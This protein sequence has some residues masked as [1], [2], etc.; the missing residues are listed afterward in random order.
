MNELRITKINRLKQIT[1][2]HKDYLGVRYKVLFERKNKIKVYKIC[3]KCG[4]VH[5]FK[6]IKCDVM[7]L[8][9]FYKV[10]TFDE[11]KRFVKIYYVTDKELRGK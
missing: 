11:T 10:W 5:K 8:S 2:K 1:C 7:S 3:I 9:N 4:R 6:T